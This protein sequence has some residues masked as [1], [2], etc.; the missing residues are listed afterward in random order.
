M[1]FKYSITHN[2]LSKNR[3]DVKKSNSNQKNKKNRDHPLN[4]KFYGGLG[5]SY[6]FLKIILH[7]EQRF[8][9]NNVMISFEKTMQKSRSG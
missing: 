4:L 2:T 1:Q 8:C 9:D 7:I 3:V 5:R 6:Q